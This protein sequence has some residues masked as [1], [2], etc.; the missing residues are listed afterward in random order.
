MNTHKNAR[1]TYAR[2]VD[3]ARRAAAP[4]ANVSQ[5]AREFD[6][7]RPT[8]RKWRDRFVADG[9]AGLTDRSSRPHRCPRQLPRFRQRQ[10][11]RLRRKRWSSIR[12]AQHY[13]LP[14][15]TVVTTQRRL[16][17]ARLDR[18][19]P[20]RPVVRYEHARP[21]ALVHLD[22]KAF[23]RIQRPGH[24]VTGSRR[25]RAHGKA[26]WEHL[27][28]AIDD[29]TRLTYA[30]VLPTNTAR[31]CAA[32]LGRLVAWF[33][34]RGVRVRALLTDNGSGYISHHFAGHVARLRLRHRRTRPRRPQTN[35]KAERVIRTLATEWAYAQ[36]YR[37]SVYR[38]AALP[39]YLHYY[40]QER[41]HTALGYTTPAQRCADRL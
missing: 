38:S 23:G 5:L 7:S 27:H 8:V 21:G 1:L 15:S 35:G 14:I 3:L 22:T 30:E 24:R 10:I 34:G 28:V 19:E 29:C 4:D 26:G 11:E 17:L 36:R 2:R 40:N 12:I 13:A 37:T 33:A 18:L 6:V 9:L 39:R 25:G 31:D 32:F 16:G 20:P 41:R